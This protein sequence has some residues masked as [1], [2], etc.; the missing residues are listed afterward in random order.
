MW[1][2]SAMGT[3][4]RLLWLIP[5][6]EVWNFNQSIKTNCTCCSLQANQRCSE[7]MITNSW[8]VL[9]INRCLGY[10]VIVMSENAKRTKCV[11]AKHLHFHLVISILLWCWIMQHLSVWCSWCAAQCLS[12]LWICVCKW[13]VS[14]D[15][16][17][18]ARTSVGAGMVVTMCL[19]V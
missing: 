1:Q 14:L 19:C 10:V 8:Y 9:V 16:E 3:G 12:K 2:H 18:C 11:M 5:V 7:L 17:M 4:R 13:K 6:I 15:W